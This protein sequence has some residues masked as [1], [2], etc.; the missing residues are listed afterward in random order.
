MAAFSCH[1]QAFLL[2]H[3]PCR[4]AGVLLPVACGLPSEILRDAHAL[5]RASLALL[6]C[7]NKSFALCGTSQKQLFLLKLTCWTVQNQDSKISC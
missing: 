4:N 2:K 3:A 5:C 6:L 7:Y 1:L